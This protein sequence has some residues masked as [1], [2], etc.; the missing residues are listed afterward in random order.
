MVYSAGFE[1]Q[2]GRKLLAG[3][4][5]AASAKESIKKSGQGVARFLY[6]RYVG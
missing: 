1:N 5:P 6:L 2:L 4:T 3:S